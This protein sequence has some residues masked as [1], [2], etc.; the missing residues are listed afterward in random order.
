MLREYYVSLRR[1]TPFVSF[2]LLV[3]GGGFFNGNGREIF[4]VKFCDLVHLV[5]R[6]YH[7]PLRRS[8]V[9]L[10]ESLVGGRSHSISPT[11]Y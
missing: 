1:D 6:L 11:G 10:C 2:V 9:L 7:N 5:N 3:G 8:P 4:E